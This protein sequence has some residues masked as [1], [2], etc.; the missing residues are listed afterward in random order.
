MSTVKTNCQTLVHG[1][2][3]GGADNS[4]QT[5]PFVC[6]GGI[7]ASLQSMC[8]SKVASPPPSPAV[9]ASGPAGV[10]VRGGWCWGSGWQLQRLGCPSLSISRQRNPV[11]APGAGEETLHGQHSPSSLCWGG[12]LAGYIQRF[13]VVQVVCRVWD[14]VCPGYTRRLLLCLIDEES[15][16]LFLILE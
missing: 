8:A 10:S 7:P 3:F 13:H 1:Q 2:L 15:G 9:A 16:G 14:F 5:R 4:L 12:C 6:R 11:P